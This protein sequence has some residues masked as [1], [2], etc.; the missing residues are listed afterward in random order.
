MFRRGDIADCASSCTP[1]LASS[2]RSARCTRAARLDRAIATAKESC[3]RAPANGHFVTNAHDPLCL[4][5]PRARAPRHAVRIHDPP[6]R[7]QRAT[8]RRYAAEHA[9]PSQKAALRSVLTKRRQAADGHTA[10]QPTRR[11]Q[12]PGGR[13]PR[14]S[15]RTSQRAQPARR[16][17]VG[18]VLDIDLRAS[19]RRS[20][21]CSPRTPASDPHPR[22]ECR[23]RRTPTT[24]I[25]MGPP[26]RSS[27]ARAS[28]HRRLLVTR[29]GRAGRARGRAKPSLGEHAGEVCDLVILVGPAATLRSA[30]GSRPPA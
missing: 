1:P 28:R 21:G 17:A 18:R 13:G 25:P 7:S 5:P 26:P 23:D 8:Q 19:P 6:A 14:G 22:A 9:P 4:E 3:G 29:D 20:R 11:A 24:P 15:A 16:P 27:P 2:P 12:Q 10:F 30:E